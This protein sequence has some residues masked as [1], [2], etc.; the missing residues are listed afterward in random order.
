MIHRII[1][2]GIRNIKDNQI[3]YLNKN[4]VDCNN[5]LNSLDF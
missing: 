4:I 3:V 1:V 2:F 5:F